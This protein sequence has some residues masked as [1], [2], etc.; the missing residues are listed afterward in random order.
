MFKVFRS[1]RFANVLSIFAL[2]FAL[3][4]TAGAASISLITGAQVKDG[5][6]AGADLANHSIGFGKLSQSAVTRLK[7]ARGATGPAGAPGAQGSTGAAGAAGATGPAGAVGTQIQLAGYAKTADQTLPDDNAFHQVWSISFKVAANQTFI[8]TG[9]L[10][11]ES[12][13]CP[14]GGTTYTSQLELDGSPF[15]LNSALL[16]FSPGSHTLSYEDKEN[17]SVAGHPVHVPVQEV[18]LIPFRLP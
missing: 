13:D 11:N 7:G 4:G 16:A 6:L 9:Q 3:A 5:S 10:G 2:V 17:C 12:T 18:V 8:I 14:D 15:S 1:T